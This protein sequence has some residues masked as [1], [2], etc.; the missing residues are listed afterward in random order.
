MA[1]VHKYNL[2]QLYKFAL[3]VLLLSNKT[4]ADIQTFKLFLLYGN[5]QNQ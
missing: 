5:L 4:H 2:G 3:S 1:I